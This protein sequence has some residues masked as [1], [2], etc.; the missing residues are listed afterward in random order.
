MRQL[1]AILQWIVEPEELPRPENV[2]HSHPRTRESIGWFLAPERLPKT[3]LRAEH[4]EWSFLKWLTAPEAL[5]RT[6]NVKKTAGHPLF[7]WIVATERLPRPSRSPSTRPAKS[8]LGWLFSADTLPRKR[9]TDQHQ[10]GEADE[11]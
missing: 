2:R 10:E 11:L 9:N 4:K 3:D 8:S 6:P 1:I 5:P 7:R